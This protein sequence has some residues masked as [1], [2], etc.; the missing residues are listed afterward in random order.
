ME[1]NNYICNCE[2]CL[3]IPCS[4]K[5]ISWATHTARMIVLMRDEKEGRKKQARSNQ[6]QGKATLHNSCLVYMTWWV[7]K[8]CLN[9]SHVNSNVSQ[10]SLFKAAYYILHN[11]YVIIKGARSRRRARHYKRAQNS[12]TLAFA[13]AFGLCSYRLTFY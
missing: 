13:V 9:S 3:H 4:M 7:L 6:Q 2:D 8:L 5:L 12:R 10:F 11:I 1:Y